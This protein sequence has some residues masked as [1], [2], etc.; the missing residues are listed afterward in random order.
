MFCIFVLL[1]ILPCLFIQ[2]GIIHRYEKNV[3]DERTTEI[4]NQ[5][6]SL[7][8][9]LS[10]ENYLTSQRRA[11]LDEA[12]D[13]DSAL[14]TLSAI[15]SGQVMVVDA[16][17]R[18]IKDSYDLNT[19]K[20]ILSP[21]VIQ[22]FRGDN[23]SSFYEKQRYLEVTV[24]VMDSAGEE[25]A[26]VVLFYTSTDS[27]QQSIEVFRSMMGLRFIILSAVIVVLAGLLSFLLIIPVRRVKTEMEQQAEAMETSQD[28]KVRSY[29]EVQDIIDE[30]NLALNR[31]RVLDESRQEFVSNVSHELK[32]PITSMKVLADSLISQEGN[33]PVE[34]YQEFMSDIVEE[35]DREDKIIN[36][37]L[38]LVRLDKKAAE[39]NIQEVNLNGL[40]KALMKRIRPIAD[41]RN[42]ELV[43]ETFRP[44]NAEVDEVKISL[45]LNNLIENAV[46]YNKEGG[47]VRVSLNADHRYFYVKVADSGAGIPPE[48]QDHIFERFYR[49]DKSHS[50]Q[51]SGTGLG[52]A[53]A[54]SAVIMH[55]GSIRVH[56]EENKGT[57]FTVRVPLKYVS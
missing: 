37:L 11:A 47:W 8:N 13:I 24:P 7:A 54:R 15:Y 21:G 34:I 6:M 30:L 35:I 41:E 19:G 22:C 2:A 44:V 49:G 32:T 3:I 38:T 18:I 40:L 17:Y 46:K 16:S 23:T 57:T 43:L 28:L 51:I 27:I 45:A 12:V 53:I 52:L 42:I 55:R 31:A 39:V 4:Q 20:T 14:S 56:S 29:T 50:N 33:V 36:D 48:E 9:K 25:I 10:R 26:G 1:G 5:C